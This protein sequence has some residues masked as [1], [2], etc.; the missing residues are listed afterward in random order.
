[1]KL[2]SIFGDHMVLQQDM[3]VPVWGWARPGE[4]VCVT[5]DEQIVYGV[6]GND[7]R[8]QVMLAPMNA[9]G[10]FTLRVEGRDAALVLNNVLIGE[11]WI[12]SGQSNMDMAVAAASNGAREIADAAFDNIRLFNVARAAVVDAPREVQGNWSV[13]APKTVG[14]F[15]AVAY[16][17]GRELHRKLG[18][19]VGLIN[20]SWGG[21]I[22]E[23]WTSREMLASLPQFREAVA[24]YEKDQ[25]NFA[26]DFA[27]YQVKLKEGEAKHYPADPGN[28]GFGK[29]WAA[30]Q[31][32]LSDWG[33]IQVPCYWQGAGMDFS[34]IVWF[35]RDVEIPADWA[36]KE[37]TLK[38][39]PC[40][41]HDTTYF[42]NVKVGATGAE[43]PNPWELPRT[44]QVPAGVARPGRNTIAVRVY[45]YVYAGGIMGSTAGLSLGPA[46]AHG[47]TRIP[48][49][50]LWHCKVEHNFG[51]ITPLALQQPLGPGNPDSP[52]IL[53]R[54]MIQPL[55]P[56]AIRGAIWYQGE[57]NVGRAAEY[58][59]LFPAMIRSWR[60]AWHQGDFP[61]FLV[62]LANYLQTPT[63]PGESAWAEL[64][65]AQF[66]ALQEPNTGMAVAIDVGEANDI[67]PRNKQDVGKRLAFQA[68]NRV[69]GRKE[70]VASGPLFAGADVEGSRMRIRFTHADGGLTANG[71]EL[72]GFAVAGADRRFV[73]AKATMEG[74]TVV[75]ES[76]EV[77]KPVA[78]RYAWANNPVC[79]L[80]NKAGLPAS[81]FRS[82]NWPRSAV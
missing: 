13:C 31:T 21:T 61:F 17:F 14:N 6:A 8:W 27:A 56:H 5:F 40:D 65:E 72:T 53:F 57:S 42:N 11:V 34:G 19:P 64:R 59:T 69:Y 22:A 24:R 67:H 39:C 29:G 9:G 25:P 45:S 37:L 55:I 80:Y 81:P 79:N 16:F 10:P 74:D 32:D 75:V 52:Y 51:Q 76:N 20:S 58:R 50:G 2:S 63:E 33:P 66:Q 7:G 18:V 68:L 26:R 70:I 43:K 38:L 48:L 3:P 35:R 36:G 44:Y 73:W 4:Q 77:P 47:S 12:A 82:D 28:I 60:E 78:V 71:G 46:G 30:P 62:Q 1:M 41:K 23:A 54:S 15:S 49:A